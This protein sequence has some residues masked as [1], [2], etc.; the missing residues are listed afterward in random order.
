MNAPVTFVPDGIG[1]LQLGI[2]IVLVIVCDHVK[3]KKERKKE[4]KKE[5]QA[6]QVTLAKQI[7]VPNDFKMSVIGR[8]CSI[9]RRHFV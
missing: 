2:V 4:R 8:S 9:C 6:V 1:P 7:F 3:K 5:I